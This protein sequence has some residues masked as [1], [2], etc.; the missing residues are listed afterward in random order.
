MLPVMETCE[1]NSFP[2]AVLNHGH[3][4]KEMPKRWE[5]V[6]LDTD[7]NYE[8]G[9]T[10]LLKENDIGVLVFTSSVKDVTALSFARCAGKL[11]IPTIHVLDNW[12]NYSIRMETDGLP[13][14]VPD[15]YTVMDDLAFRGAWKDGVEGSVIFLTGQP[16]LASLSREYLSWRH[17]HGLARGDEGTYSDKIK[18]VFVSEPVE[19]D[20]GTSP[21]FPG[22]RGYTEK[23]ILSLF[24]KAAERFSEKL[25][26]RLLP[27]PREDR[28]GLWAHW[29]SC[30][31]SLKGGMLFLDRGRKA[32]FDADAVVGM[33]SVLLYE[34]WLLGK[35][36]ASLQP[37]LTKDSLGMLKNRRG[38][39]FVD[40]YEDAESRLEKWI[41]SLRPGVWNLPA[42]EMDLH[43]NAPENVFRLIERFAGKRAALR[44]N[45]I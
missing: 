11:F 28:T 41:S 27:H 14:F 29:K 2:F 38:V 12:T 5:T 4:A 42:P 43:E 24:C 13:A 20:Q 30:C 21:A 33:A 36:V 3:I 34:A 18:L 37:G 40:R 9:I 19:M 6:S 22:Y 45:I 8:D 1:E 15:A 10:G 25:E 32:L 26:I 35:P 17:A 31:G 39:L 7:T 16:A 23:D 44:R